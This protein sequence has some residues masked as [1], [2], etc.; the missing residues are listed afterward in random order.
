MSSSNEEELFQS[1]QRPQ[2]QIYTEEDRLDYSSVDSSDGLDGEDNATIGEVS[3]VS[4]ASTAVGDPLPNIAAQDLEEKETSSEERSPAPNLPPSRPNRYRGPPSTWRNWTAPER[5]LA[6]S[7]DQL[8][9]KDISIHLYNAFM[10]KKPRGTKA[11]PRETELSDDGG[12]GLDG[13][14]YW[15]P[16]KVWTAWPL[17]PVDVPR[18]EEGRRWEAVTTLP[19]PFAVKGIM[20]SELLR[21]LLVAQILRKARGQFNDRESEDQDS[22]ASETGSNKSP[23]HSPLVIDRD[24][25]IKDLKPVVM[26]DDEGASQILQ[27]TVQHVMTKIDDLLLGLHHARR[28]YLTVDIAAS[29]SE[30]QINERSTSQRKVKKRRHSA[31]TRDTDVDMASETEDASTRNS[32]SKSRSQSKRSMST[33][34]S[35]SSRNLRN[36]MFRMGCR[37][38]SDLLGVASM[39]GWPPGV[40]ERTAA[41]CAS[42]FGE[43]ITFRT[44]EEGSPGFAE[45]IY[46]PDDVCPVAVSRG[47]AAMVGKVVPGIGKE[48]KEMV[49]GVHVDGFL[50]PIE[51]KKSW[52]YPKTGAKK[53]GTSRESSG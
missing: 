10:L 18:E 41:R 44:L 30:S 11:Q 13:S 8:A 27:P 14:D 1:A 48:Q 23:P 31:S 17:P 25:E 6:A 51:G 32:V 5:D 36:R 33:S 16:P 7:L 52:K 45:R 9:A 4:Q 47:K 35:R 34:R 40:V 3:H 21:E 28:S 12:D 24:Q 37:D 2:D 29:D 22:E 20:S 26:T 42:L 49:G 39:T 43:G 46:Q 15:K 38:W 53:R 19:K 50:Q